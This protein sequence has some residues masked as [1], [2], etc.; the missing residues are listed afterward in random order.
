MY[1]T[2]KLLEMIA[3]DKSSIRYEACEWLR[4]SQESCPEIIYALQKASH[5]PD[6]EVAGRAA[7]ALQA[8]IHHSLAV[9][10]GLAAPDERDTAPAALP[11]APLTSGPNADHVAMLAGIRSWGVWSL[12][13]G[14]ISLFATGIFSSPWGVLLLIVGLASFFFRT[15]SMYIIYGVT[16][17]WAAIHNFSGFNLTWVI[18]SL[19]QVYATVRV[20][21]S[22]RRYR[23]AEAEILA[24][25]RE[26]NPEAVSAR[27]ASVYF[28][29]IGAFLG[30]L[31]FI[32]V[33]LGFLAALVIS[34][35]QKSASAV[36][37]YIY[38]AI[39][40][41][42]NTGVLGFALGLAS[43]LS[44]YRPK[45]LGVLALVAGALTLLIDLGFIV[46]QLVG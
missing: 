21:L 11:V 5:D 1:S 39:D 33:V 42:I 24:Q 10:L 27:R 34:I 2:P 32:G 22:Y 29:W 6:T 41:T 46:I 36:P 31:S 18:F 13:W 4:V 8:D 15:A 38:Y 44:R 25:P 23:R 37:G 30:C 7:Y 28:P 14:G 40:L 9:Q 45:I 16:L 17:A 43:I 35:E 19:V 20:F 3:S 12:L 26:P